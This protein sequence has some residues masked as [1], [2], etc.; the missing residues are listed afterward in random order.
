MDKKSL[1]LCLMFFAVSMFV[2][3]VTCTWVR[4][5]N[6]EEVKDENIFFP[7]NIKSPL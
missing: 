5:F 7:L 2:G 3:Y 1:Y 4:V 6:Q